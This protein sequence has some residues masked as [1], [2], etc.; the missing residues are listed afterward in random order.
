MELLSA[1]GLKLSGIKSEFVLT[2]VE[3]LGRII[4]NGCVYPKFDKL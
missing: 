3:L 2:E 1:Y 4:K